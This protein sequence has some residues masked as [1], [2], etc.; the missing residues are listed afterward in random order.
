MNNAQ[1]TNSNADSRTSN[2]NVKHSPKVSKGSAYDNMVLLK[3]DLYYK[4]IVAAHAGDI[5]DKTNLAIKE[6]L[7]TFKRSWISKRE[8]FV[9]LEKLRSGYSCTDLPVKDAIRA[10]RSKN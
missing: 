3:K 8:L 2:K 9:E 7:Y 4:S 6:I 10:I 5:A 1:T